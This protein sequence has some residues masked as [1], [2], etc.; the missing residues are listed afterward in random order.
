MEAVTVAIITGLVIYCGMRA[1]W[2]GYGL[3]RLFTAKLR[4]S[5]ESTEGQDAEES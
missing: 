4:R 2:H 5:Q 1:I 3:S